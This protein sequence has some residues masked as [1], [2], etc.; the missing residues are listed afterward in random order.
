MAPHLL[1]NTFISETPLSKIEK[2]GK[3]GSWINVHYDNLIQRKIIYPYRKVDIFKYTLISYSHQK[4]LSIEINFDSESKSWNDEVLNL[5]KKYFK[6][7]R[8]YPRRNLSRDSFLEH[9]IALRSDNVDWVFYSPNHDHPINSISPFN[10]DSL[11]DTASELRSSHPDAIVSIAYSHHL[12]IISTLDSGSLFYGVNNI[13]PK[14]LFDCDDY[15]VARYPRF[16]PDSIQIFHINDLIEL[17]KRTSRKEIRRT[18]CM[19][20]IFTTTWKSHIL[21]IPKTEFCRHFDS[22]FHLDN[23]LVEQ[24]SILDYIPPLTIPNGIFD[25]NIVFDEIT[26]TKILLRNIDGK[27]ITLK[28][29]KDVI[30]YF[31]RAHSNLNPKQ[32]S[33]LDEFNNKFM[34]EKFDFNAT[35][36]LIIERKLRY[37][38]SLLKKYLPIF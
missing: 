1:I 25:D 27:N 38:K 9:L 31:W 12:E 23:L 6:N 34:L 35:K 20:D 15:A 11:I 17:F 4:W 37:I 30:P 16:S 22:Y 13:F 14:I 7:S 28:S 33:C 8:V 24:R 2:R 21:I 29:G 10:L 36:P 5:T 3:G 19:T 18:E 32:L 26:N